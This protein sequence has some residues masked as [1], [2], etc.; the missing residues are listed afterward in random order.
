M[1]TIENGT[2]VT[3]TVPS[4]PRRRATDRRPSTLVVVI[5][6]PVDE[7]LNPD[8]DAVRRAVSDVEDRLR[9]GQLL[10]LR[11]TVYPGVTRLVDR[12]VRDLGVDVD[13][14]FC[15]E[16]IA[17]GK[18]LTE[19]YELPQLVSGCADRPWPARRSCSACSPTRSSR[20]SPRRPSWPSCSPT[21]GATSSSPSANQFFMIA[22]DFGVDYE[23]M[24]AA[25][26]HD[27][28]RAKDLPG[29]G[30]AAGPCLFKDT[31]AGGLQQQ[32]LPARHA[33]MLVNEGCRSTWS[34]GSSS[35]TTWR[36]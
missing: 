4:P 27:Y 33:S 26:T 18:A 28:P 12:Y 3:G 29:A 2:G 11:S 32:Q 6:T 14:A 16:R 17:E 10:V 30:F 7:H 9:D 22:N 35:S 21:P 25:I 19:L 34:P 24:R 23:R 31:A 1:T 15:P 5:G 36:R 8:P 13:V 20:S